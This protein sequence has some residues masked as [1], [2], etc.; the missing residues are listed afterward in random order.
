M[1]PKET[2]NRQLSGNRFKPFSYILF[3]RLTA[4]LLI[5]AFETENPRLKAEFV[6]KRLVYSENEDFN[7][8]W[9]DTFG[10]FAMGTCSYTASE[11]L[12]SLDHQAYVSEHTAFVEGEE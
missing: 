2:A 4:S 10:E 3:E 12:F 5:R 9:D 1:N 11:I 7:E 8:F 6:D